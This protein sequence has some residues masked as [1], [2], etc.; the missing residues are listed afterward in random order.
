[1]TSYLGLFLVFRW[2]HEIN[3]WWH[4]YTWDIYISQLHQQPYACHQFA[5]KKASQFWYHGKRIQPTKRVLHLPYNISSRNNKFAG[6][7]ND[8]P[9]DTCASF[10]AV[11]SNYAH[12]NVYFSIV[13]ESQS[14]IFNWVIDKLSTLNIIFSVQEQKL[15]ECVVCQRKSFFVSLCSK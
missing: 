14:W 13:F 5:K 8:D 11:Q 6:N 4:R 2:D 12:L 9:C 7:Q 3:F 15:P 1:M 10:L